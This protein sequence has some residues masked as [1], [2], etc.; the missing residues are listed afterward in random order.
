[1][2]T[3]LLAL[4]ALA[5]PVL[6]YVGLLHF[7]VKWVALATAALLLLRLLLLQQRMNETGR[8]LYPAI[9][10][11]VACALASVV[12]DHAGALRLIPVV[13]NFACLVA[14]A[15][16]L[17]HPP[18]MI[19]RFARLTEPDLSPVAVAYTRRVTQVW[20]AFFVFNGSI[21]FYTAVWA[22]MATWTL[23][24]GLVAYLLMGALGA[25]EYLVRLRVKARTA[26]P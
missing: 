10:L 2:P 25:V 3:A 21:A 23:Y 7:P 1:M 16:T 14:F 22:S 12:L 15:L 6:V 26:A 18:S 24:N 8:A 17:R 20:C 11:S 19:E 4:L 9:A 13:I 5:Y